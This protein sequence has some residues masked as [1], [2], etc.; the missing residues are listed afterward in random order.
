MGWFNQEKSKMKDTVKITFYMVSGKK[1][2]AIYSK[3]KFEEMLSYLEKN[4]E[5]VTSTGKLHGINFA[6]VTHY[7]VKE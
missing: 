6:H 2:R 3:D 7:E 5:K 4:W 1:F